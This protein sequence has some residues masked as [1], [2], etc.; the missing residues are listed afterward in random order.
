KDSI[1]KELIDRNSVRFAESYSDLA[2]K[3]K[4][5]PDV[6]KV[7]IDH[8][9]RLNFITLSNESIDGI[10][11]LQLNSEAHNFHAHGGFH[12]KE[13]ILHKNIERLLLEIESLK[14]V[15]PDKV[16]TLTGIAANIA[17]ALSLFIK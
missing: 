12:G 1:L 10:F 3:H 17:T 16:S 2:A 4:V 7:I 6:I 15:F 11:L 8:F 5:A 14:P 13:Q 9:I